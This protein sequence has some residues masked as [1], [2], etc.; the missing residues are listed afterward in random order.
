MAGCFYLRL[1]WYTSK[2]RLKGESMVDGITVEG[3]NQFEV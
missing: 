2:L 1:G 3:A